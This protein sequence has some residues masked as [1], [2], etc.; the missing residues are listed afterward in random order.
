MGRYNERYRP[1]IVKGK[2]GWDPR[3]GKLYKTLLRRYRLAMTQSDAWKARALEAEN[4]IVR[5][6]NKIYKLKEDC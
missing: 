3:E 5:L 6:K 1:L 2:T 4:E